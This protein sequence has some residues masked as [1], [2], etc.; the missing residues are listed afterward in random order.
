MSKIFISYRRSDTGYQ[1]EQIKTI[2]SKYVSED[3]I[4]YDHVIDPGEN[5]PEILN[6]RLKSAKV[7]LVLIGRDWLSAL[8]KRQ[9]DKN[10]M[11]YVLLE[12]ERG[13]QKNKRDKSF[14]IYPI[15]FDGEPMPAAK[16]LPESLT[17]LTQF[18]AISISQNE[19]QQKISKLGYEICADINSTIQCFL[20]KHLKLSIALFITLALAILCLIVCK[21]EPKCLA[22][23][24][25]DIKILLIPNKDNNS[26][27]AIQQSFIDG[28]SP[29]NVL[30]EFMKGKTENVSINQLQILSE[31]CVPDVTIDQ[32]NAKD[33]SIIYKSDEI[34]TYLLREFNGANFNST[35]LKTQSELNC[36][37]LSYLYHKSKTNATS[38]AKIPC[39]SNIKKSDK[40]A[41]TDTL[42]N[43]LV[44]SAALIFEK[45]NMPDSAL[46]YLS[47]VEKGGLNPDTVYTRIAR[48]AMQ[49]KNYTKNI[50]ANTELIK[51]AEA[52]KNLQAKENHLLN[53]AQAYILNSDVSNAKKDIDVLKSI[54]KNNSKIEELEKQISSTRYKCS[55]GSCV[56]FISTNSNEGF[57]SLTLCTKNCNPTYTR[58]KCSNG[59]C[60]KF[61][62]TNNNEGFSSMNLCQNNCIPTYTRYKCSN[63]SCVKFITTNSNEGYSS[64]NLCQNSCNPFQGN[65]KNT[66]ASTKG[67][68]RIDI[69]YSG[70]KMNVQCYGK[71]HPTDCKWK[72]IS[73]PVTSM[74]TQLYK[75][76][77]NDGIAMRSITLSLSQSVLKVN[78]T[79]DYLD[80]RPTRNEA[81]TFKR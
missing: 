3:V 68:T 7:M 19:I 64:V 21:Q 54:N 48:T 5:F 74:S 49:I 77:L 26:S 10:T 73:V 41:A 53:R 25:G 58:Y 50:S 6:K 22:F 8:K 23:A 38:I 57:A 70:T 9:K 52:S 75:V 69:S 71:C 63:G 34:K 62:S 40:I 42:G 17:A 2:L 80:T 31:T 43:A 18:N 76:N 11:D 60:V 81:Y 66:D 15:L 29:F 67:I 16:D 47:M 45:N 51:I 28:L 55:S 79:S 24:N 65:W 56:N 33:F 39:L 27:L 12:I 46:V 13:L 44:Q 37:L 30:V 32:R 1:P 36:I 14:K 4:F 78:M 72:T 35:N 61:I 20:K 59:S